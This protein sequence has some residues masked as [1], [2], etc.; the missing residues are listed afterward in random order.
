MR[1]DTFSFYGAGE[2][3]FLRHDLDAGCGAAA[4]GGAGGS[5]DDGAFWALQDVGRGGD[6]A[7]GWRLP[8]MIYVVMAVTIQRECVRLLAKEAGRLLFRIC[9]PVIMR[10]GSCIRMCHKSC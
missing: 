3:L 8:V 5:W 2:M 6:G 10:W 4:V 9:T 7:R 1:E